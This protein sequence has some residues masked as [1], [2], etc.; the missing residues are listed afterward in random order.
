MVIKQ[1]NNEKTI[2][3]RLEAIH[4][5]LMESYGGGD[6]MTRST[7]GNERELFA[8]SFLK[9]VF[10]PNFRFSSGDITDTYEKRSGQ[11]DIVGEYPSSISFPIFPEAPRLFLAEGVAFVIEVKSDLS[12]QWE[13]L[14]STAEKV[15]SIRRKYIRQEIEEAISLLT[16]TGK[17]KKDTG[18]LKAA[19]KKRG[20]LRYL[21]N[22]AT[23]KIPVIG[24]GY[25]GWKN[26]DKVKE[27]LHS[28]IDVDAVLLI[29][30]LNF[31]WRNPDGRIGVSNGFQSLIAFLQYLQKYL[32][33]TPYIGDLAWNYLI[34][35]IEY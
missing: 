20:T 23:E 35:P 14:L 12:N 28:A 10:P 4:K 17:E 19:D 11:V 22:E 30:I 32:G 31:S 5:V 33:R 27:K 29:D 26:P 6:K 8:R 25:N 1:R 9:Q 34:G 7:K 16:K 13:Q 18:M 24:V 2:Q 15:K 3:K 21:H